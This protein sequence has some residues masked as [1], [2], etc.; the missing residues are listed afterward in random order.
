MGDHTKRTY[1][2]RVCPDCG[3][4]FMSS[5]P[6]KEAIRCHECGKKRHLELVKISQT[7]NKPSKRE[8]SIDDR[9]K[10]LH[11]EIIYDPLQS[12]GYGLEGLKIGLNELN[13]SLRLHSFVTGT[14]IQNIK[15]N[16]IITV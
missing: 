14:K 7:K 10:H 6:Q 16:E 13:A 12:K 2:E 3:E 5:C 4:T 9:D 8:F 15:T 1:T 11:Y